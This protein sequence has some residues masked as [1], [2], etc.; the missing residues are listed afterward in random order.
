VLRFVGKFL[1]DLAK[2]DDSLE[3]EDALKGANKKK[4]TDSVEEV[5]SKKGPDTLAL[6][7]NLEKAIPQ[8]YQAGSSNTQITL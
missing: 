2:D 1:D 4:K 5:E 6:V 8:E 3:G 7:D